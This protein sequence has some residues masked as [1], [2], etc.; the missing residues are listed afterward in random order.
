M[1]EFDTVHLET[2]VSPSQQ[3]GRNFS[4]PWL[5]DNEHAN[6]VINEISEDIYNIDRISPKFIC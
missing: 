1:D 3:I 2:L 4:S 6:Y 5:P